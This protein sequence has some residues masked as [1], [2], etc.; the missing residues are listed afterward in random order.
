MSLKKEGWI[1]TPPKLKMKISVMKER[2]SEYNS[3]Q[4]KNEDQCH[5]RKKVG[6][7]LLPN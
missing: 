4:T 2:R 6:V 5:E 3:S 1:T 7:Q